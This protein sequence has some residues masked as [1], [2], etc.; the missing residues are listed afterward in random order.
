MH[1]CRGIK[2]KNSYSIGLVLCT[3]CFHNYYFKQTLAVFTSTQ[4]I[5]ALRQLDGRTSD[6]IFPSI[7]WSSREE[8][9]S[10]GRTVEWK[11][12]NLILSTGSV[13]KCD[14]GLATGPA[15]PP[16]S[17]PR[18]GGLD[19][20]FS[21]PVYRHGP[22]VKESPT[23]PFIFGLNPTLYFPCR[24]CAG[25]YHNKQSRFKIFQRY[26]PTCFVLIANRKWD[27][28]IFT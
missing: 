22:H 24:C 6:H 3:L 5:R 1:S 2:L 15:R 12:E 17:Q 26:V 21:R 14:N 13:A 27:F 18:P 8:S 28:K 9:G 16:G 7:I 23:P 10:Y 4:H 11:V 20:Q 19:L 25:Q